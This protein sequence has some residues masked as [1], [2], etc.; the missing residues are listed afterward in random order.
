MNLTCRQLLPWQLWTPGTFHAAQWLFRLWGDSPFR[1]PAP[2]T[3]ARQNLE[4]AI[5]QHVLVE[6]AA[7]AYQKGHGVAKKCLGEQH[8][9]T[10]L[11]SCKNSRGPRLMLLQQTQV[12]ATA[13]PYERPREPC[14]RARKTEYAS[15]PTPTRQPP[16]QTLAKNADVA[17]LRV[18]VT[19]MRCPVR[20]PQSDAWNLFPSE[21]PQFLGKA[22]VVFLLLLPCAFAVHRCPF[23]T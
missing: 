21:S 2:S 17:G 10:C 12:I 19:I 1:I 6:Q 5:S 9:L 11:G 7:A 22:V 15:I 18:F 20:G 13:L 14:S 3:K 8:P 23:I 4:H 16:R